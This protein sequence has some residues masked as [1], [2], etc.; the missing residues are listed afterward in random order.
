MVSDLFLD[1]VIGVFP[2]VKAA[3]DRVNVFETLLNQDLR[4]TG[5]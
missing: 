3:Q 2:G 5:G 4:R 1:R